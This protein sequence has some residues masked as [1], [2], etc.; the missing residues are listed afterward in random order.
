M[1]CKLESK[2]EFK[3]WMHQTITV[4]QTDTRNSKQVNIRDADAL[5]LRQIHLAEI[6][7]FGAPVTASCPISCYCVMS[8]LV[9]MSLHDMHEALNTIILKYYIIFKILH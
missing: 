1:L 3:L 4:A 2:M 7:Q 8:D 5:K 9:D 6:G